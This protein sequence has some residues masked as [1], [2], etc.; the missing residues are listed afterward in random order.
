MNSL[1]AFGAHGVV[2]LLLLR[3][4]LGIYAVDP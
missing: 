2:N 1:M 3:T 4:F